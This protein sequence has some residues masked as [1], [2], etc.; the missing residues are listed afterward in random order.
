[1]AI[2]GYLILG[3]I[4]VGIVYDKYIQR[5]HQLLINYP[6][7]GRFRYFFEA[8]R[9]PFRQYFGDEN[10][11]ESKD[12]IDWVYNAAHDKAGFASFSPTQPQPNPKFLLKQNKQ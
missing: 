6:L 11:Y 2:I 12:K 4:I 10:F 5:E 8:V 9:E 3:L 7:I 1:M